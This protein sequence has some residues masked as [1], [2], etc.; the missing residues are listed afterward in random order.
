MPVRDRFELYCWLALIAANAEI[1]S[2]DWHLLV[3]ARLSLCLPALHFIPLQSILIALVTI[4][5]E[6][7]FPSVGAL[8]EFGDIQPSAA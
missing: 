5:E 1:R 3:L 6:R 8:G 7:T 4:G 2:L